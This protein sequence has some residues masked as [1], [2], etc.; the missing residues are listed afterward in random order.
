ME[1]DCKQENER[2]EVRS[3]KKKRE[4]VFIHA[5]QKQNCFLS[6]FPYS[7][8]RL[9]TMRTGCQLNCKKDPSQANP[10]LQI[11]LHR[12]TNITHKNP[13]NTLST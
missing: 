13:S 3:I 4:K 6:P 9:V 8:T 10:P 1:K 12:H 5:R 7:T 11:P 2:E